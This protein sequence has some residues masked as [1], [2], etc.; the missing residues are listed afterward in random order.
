M[1]NLFPVGTT[2]SSS[3]Q[4]TT[5]SVVVVNSSV[6]SVASTSLPLGRCINAMNQQFDGVATYSLSTSV[7]ADECLTMCLEDPN[8]VQYTY[9]D[10]STNDIWTCFLA[11]QESIV[12][13]IFSSHYITGYGL[14]R[15]ATS[16]CVSSGRC[17]NMDV[18]INRAGTTSSIGINVETPQQCQCI[19]VEDP[20]CFTY[21]WNTSQQ[22]ATYQTFPTF[23]DE[24]SSE[25]VS[26]VVIDPPI[27]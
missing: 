19:C 22:C 21:T 9:T 11:N 27:G 6:S 13:G 18:G 7:S 10:S 24:N 25:S 3:I 8:C 23:I 15:T 26:G 12:S 17:S 20:N 4:P 16:G 5:S 2:S 1:L 14:N